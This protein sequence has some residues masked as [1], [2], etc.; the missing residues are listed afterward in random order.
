MRHATHHSTSKVR[1][2]KKTIFSVSLFSS[3]FAITLI[4]VF[5]ATKGL[6]PSLSELSFVEHSSLGRK[7]GTVIPAS[8]DSSPVYS[9]FVGDTL[10]GPGS[11]CD[12]C[13]LSSDP[14]TAANTHF[15]DPTQRCVCDNGGGNIPVCTAPVVQIAFGNSYPFLIASN[16]TFTVDETY[17]EYGTGGT[18]LRWVAT[19]ATSC[20]LSGSLVVASL[21]L[22]SGSRHITSS[23]GAQKYILTC[24]DGSSTVVKTLSVHF[25]TLTESMR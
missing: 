24:T 2:L 4:S 20:S 5:F 18:Y 15:D 23:G 8:C 13:K 14:Q 7:A 3:F 6:T 10:T 25:E 19:G 17:V 21:A 1:S 11:P 12:P 16:V 22:P 9:H